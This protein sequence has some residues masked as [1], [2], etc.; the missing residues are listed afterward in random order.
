MSKKNKK[1]DHS[2]DQD[3]IGL[4]KTAGNSDNKKWLG[5]ARTGSAQEGTV[6]AKVQADFYQERIRQADSKEE[7]E[8]IQQRFSE[9]MGKERHCQQNRDDG[10]TIAAIFQ[11]IAA[12]IAFGTARYL[13]YKKN[14]E[15]LIAVPISSTDKS[16]RRISSLLIKNA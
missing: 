2:Q 8:E 11:P 7:S 12:A 9:D 14:N 1:A 3:V 5:D 16:V 10:D 15:T 13:A 6:R 4:L